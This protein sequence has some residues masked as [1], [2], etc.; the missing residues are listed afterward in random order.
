MSEIQWYI[1]I[2]AGKKAGP[3][4]FER[5]RQIARQG[6]IFPTTNVR[7]TEDGSV[8]MPAKDVSGLYEEDVE[9]TATGNDAE[10]SVEAGE[11]EQDSP[12]NEVATETEPAQTPVVQINVG[13]PKEKSKPV[14]KT[15]FKIDPRKGSQEKKKR[16]TDFIV[17]TS[18]KPDTRKIELDDDIAIEDASSIINEPP[19]DT[20]TV[21]EIPQESPA[22]SKLDLSGLGK[23]KKSERSSASIQI[24]PAGTEEK[25]ERKK[26][27][28][29]SSAAVKISLGVGGGGVEKKKSSEGS[30]VAVKIGA[31]GKTGKKTEKPVK[32]VGKE[33][34][35]GKALAE[36]AE[37]SAKPTREKNAKP[38]DG[39][40]VPKIISIL[41][42]LFGLGGGGA[43]IG[44]GWENLGGPLAG[45]LGGTLILL[46]VLLGAT[47][48]MLSIQTAKVAALTASKPGEQSGLS[49]R[50]A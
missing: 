40:L 46:G 5:L 42:F 41:G 20:G 27:S 38:S 37:K 43:V 2:G 26:A 19:R 28:D 47:A 4:S 33:P 36:K 45:V 13:P 44:L 7:N 15:A 8:W 3:I 31:S 32:T 21:E 34:V 22:P 17:Q 1:Q 16:Q 11:P 9:E 39:T 29:G 6:K 25:A 10:E 50:E 35:Q 48:W 12:E 49:E 24:G 30:S 18:G 14:K 23:P